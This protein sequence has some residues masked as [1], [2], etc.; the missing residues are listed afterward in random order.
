M[1]IKKI[2]VLTSG[3]D[4]P[5]MNSAVRA[6]V[7][8]GLS[9]GFEMIGVKRGYHGLLR[10]EFVEMESGSVSNFNQRGGTVLQ[11]ARSKH[12]PTPE[13]IATAVAN[14][15]EAGIDAMIVIGGDGSFRGA[16]KLTENGLPTI[17]IPA[18]IDNDISCTDYTLGFDTAMNTAMD[19]I[20][21]IKDTAASHERCSIA[22]VM[23]RGAGYIALE[24]G[25]ATGAE[26]I[27]IPEKDKDTS[28]TELIDRIVN[29]I[30]DGE[31]IG[32]K[33]H[34]VVIAEGVGGS[35]EIAKAV[36]ERTGIETRATILGHIQRGG[37]P[38]VRD[39]YIAAQMGN[40][41]IELLKQGK[42]NRVVI[43]KGNHIGDLDIN[44]GL[45]MKKLI[46]EDIYNLADMLSM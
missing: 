19:C 13:G 11:T 16:Q 14:A 41:A 24:V 29:K 28:K 33:H 5:G 32:R 7:R 6:V 15:K 36:E 25:I 12:F 46:S 17:G 26:V 37:S 45:S 38:S 2:G 1:K 10:G 34:I 21:K 9:N 4:A 35:N 22:E 40:K 42:S 43:L 18:T 30:T 27:I 23:G 39:R 44:E 31:R 3:G 20:D 8:C